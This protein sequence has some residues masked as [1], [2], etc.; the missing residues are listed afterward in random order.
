MVDSLDSLD[1]LPIVETEIR[2]G[3][4]L[5]EELIS[6]EEASRTVTDGPDYYAIRSVLPEVRDRDSGVLRVR[7]VATLGSGA[8]SSKDDL[9][10][11]QEVRELLARHR[12]LDPS[13]AEAEEVLR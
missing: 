10:G 3:E 7:P 6:T 8:Y 2:P 1:S 13:L 5:H 11:G 4:K 9:M 12:L